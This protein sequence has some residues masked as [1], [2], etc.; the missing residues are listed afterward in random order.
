MK[1]LQELNKIIDNDREFLKEMMFD[2]CMENRDIDALLFIDIITGKTRITGCNK[3]E[4]TEVFVDY[5]AGFDFT[6][7]VFEAMCFVDEEELVKKYGVE[8][9]YIE[10]KEDLENSNYAFGDFLCEVGKLEEFKDEVLK[11]IEEDYYIADISEEEYFKTLKR[12]EDK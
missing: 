3:S 11:E 9:E 4:S 7:E 2:Y 12:L 8:K 5:F 1:T 10:A 6:Q